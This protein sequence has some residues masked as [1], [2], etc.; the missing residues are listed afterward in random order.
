MLTP[1]TTSALTPFDWFLLLVILI[2]TLTAFQKGF[3]RV[4]LS[5]GGLVVGVIVASW[6]YLVVANW[7]HQWVVSFEVSEVVAFILLLI[8]VMIVFSVVAQVLRKTAKV[9][10]LGFVDRVLGAGVGFVRGLLIGVAA[11]MALTAFVPDSAWIKNSQLAPYF[12]GGVHAVS[13]VVP[14]HFQQQIASGAR[15]LLHETPQLFRPHTLQQ[16]M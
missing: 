16:H 4:L 2:S 6:E 11:M 1:L 14:E 10:G 3:I 8:M 7:L 13:F 5:I 12:L 9:I 15:Y